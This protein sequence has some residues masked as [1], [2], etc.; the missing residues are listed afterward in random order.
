MELSK[1]LRARRVFCIGW[2][3]ADHIRELSTRNAE[4]CTIFMKPPTC[5]VPPG[6]PVAIP[7]GQGAVHHEVELVVAL[8]REGRDVPAADALGWVAGVTLGLDLTLRE[9]QARLKK[10]GQ[11]WELCKAFDQSAP[12][13]DL[14]PWTP[15]IDLRD[16]TLRCLVNGQLRQEG[17]TRDMLFP[18]ERLIEIVSRTWR[19]LPGDLIFTGTPPGVGPIVP[20][21]EL[22]IE[23]PRI[24][25]FAWAIV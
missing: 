23:S 5:L 4:Q 14:V 24:G 8:G 16:V 1:E 6:V 20:G 9:V 7:R 17:N 21:D 25:R 22:V 11:P 3:Y 19:L 18:V 2:N 10:L 13:G 12:L 15:A